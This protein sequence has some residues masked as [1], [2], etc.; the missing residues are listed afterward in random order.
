MA[1]A[2]RTKEETT[3]NGLDWG[4]FGDRIG[5]A[6]RLLRNELTVRISDAQGPFGV[7][8]GGLSSM[9]LIHANPGCSQADLAR[10]LAL[11]KSVLVAIVDDLE[12]QGF[13]MRG[14]STIDRRRNSL[15]LTEDGER[16]MRAMLERVKAV[17]QPIADALN[18]EEH[19]LLI[20]LLR[21]AYGALAASGVQGKD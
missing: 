15:T 7:H 20:R 13:A 21:R 10:E 5:P 17:E 16:V 4:L 2:D 14:R 3:E 8:S 6:V 1:K 19:A 11:D 18:P 9:V 12:R